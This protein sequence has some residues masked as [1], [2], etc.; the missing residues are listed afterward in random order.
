M[1]SQTSVKEF[2]DKFAKEVLLKDF[3]TINLRQLAIMELCDRFVPSG[4]RILEIGCGTGILSKFL[5]RKASFITSVDIS[6]TNICIAKEYAASPINSF[7]VLDI[8]D[9][10]SGSL[11]HEKFD[12][13]ILPD[14]IEHI[15]RKNHRKLFRKI[16]QM[17]ELGGLVVITLPS[18]EYQKYLKE[19]QPENLQVIDETLSIPEVL[20]ATS[21]F[22]LYFSYRDAWG[23]NQ[24][25]HL[26]LSSKVD[27]TPVQEK[28]LLQAIVF[29]I[30][31]LLWHLS[32]VF[33]LHRIKNVS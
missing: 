24:Y 18:P 21:L 33:F 28:S 9:D 25:I 12:V 27:Y 23:R 29:K 15:S 10:V 1:S 14:I 32:N 11:Q 8:V 20:S 30:R 19:Y 13:I 22:P 6:E 16:E 2:Y 26:I 17:L 31:N 3:Y 7:E 5:Q 4:A